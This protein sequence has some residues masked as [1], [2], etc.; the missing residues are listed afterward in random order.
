MNNILKERSELRKNKMKKFNYE[1]SSKGTGD[2]FLDDDTSQSFVPTD[3]KGPLPK[4]SGEQK[5][6]SK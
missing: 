1:F 3:P 6:P 4:I 5:I 2:D